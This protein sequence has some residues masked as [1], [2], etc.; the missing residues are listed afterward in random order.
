MGM[1]NP[2]HG[3]YIGRVFAAQGGYS[4]SNKITVRHI[5]IEGTIAGENEEDIG[6]GRGVNPERK[7]CAKV[8]YVRACVAH[9]NHHDLGHVGDYAG[10]MGKMR[11]EAVS[12]I[13]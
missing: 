1:G 11:G 5:R 4:T 6:G 12:H 2:R 3:V 8:G 7:K 9:G 13:G 10:D